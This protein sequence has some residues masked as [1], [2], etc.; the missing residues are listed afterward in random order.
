MKN[1]GQV[2]FVTNDMSCYECAGLPLPSV[3]DTYANE[4]G[5]TC[6]LT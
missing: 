2:S 5:K 6:V 4:M 3:K 1:C